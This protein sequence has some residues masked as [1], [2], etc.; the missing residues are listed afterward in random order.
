[1]WFKTRVH[2]TRTTVFFQTQPCRHTIEQV[3]RFFNR[4]LSAIYLCEHALIFF[5]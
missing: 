5:G 4:A 2:T 3:H 1:M